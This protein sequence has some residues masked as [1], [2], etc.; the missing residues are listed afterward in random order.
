[1]KYKEPDNLCNDVGIQDHIFSQAI[2]KKIST[3]RYWDDADT[4]ARKTSS[5]HF[6]RGNFLLT[7]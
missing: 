7:R 6:R 4:N 1:M 5:F 2:S 3:Y